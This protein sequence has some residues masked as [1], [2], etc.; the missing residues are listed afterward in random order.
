MTMSRMT[1]SPKTARTNKNAPILSVS[2]ENGANSAYGSK[3][4]ILLVLHR[5]DSVYGHE[6]SPPDLYATG[7]PLDGLMLTLLS[8]NTNDRN[9]DA[10]YESLRGLFP[11]WSDVA[12]ASQNEI[13][14]AIKSAGLGEIK[15]A[16]MKVILSKIK[17]D[18]GEHSLVAMKGWDASLVREYL[19]SF[20][21][22]G[23]KTVA[24][25]MA[26]DLGLPAFPVDTH[27]ARISRRLG[28]AREKSSPEKIQDFLEATVPAEHCG[29]GHLNMIEHGRKI[30]HARNQ[31]C[32]DCVVKDICRSLG[33][34]NAN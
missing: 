6:S 14:T 5:L 10:A 28:W 4:H 13:A 16:R 32:A 34:V 24:C 26:F 18:F 8:Q 7:E 29:G 3:E 33:E 2:R 21:G 20:H 27:V 15:S 1:T 31:K 12:G 25:V 23:P 22:I 17:E 19:S 9:R 11:L 30:C